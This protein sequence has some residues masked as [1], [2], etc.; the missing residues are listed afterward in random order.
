M[1]T[2]GSEEMERGRSKTVSCDTIRRKI[3]EFLATKEMNKTTFL[4]EIGVN[5]TSL[6]NFMKLKGAYSGLQNG[7]YRGAMEFF[8]KRKQEAK[9][10]KKKAVKKRKAA[11][12]DEEE[13]EEVEE[14]ENEKE[15]ADDESGE[16]EEKKKA[17]T[18]KKAKRAS[19]A[20]NTAAE[21]LQKLAAHP[22]SEDDPVFD[23]CDEVRAKILAFMQSKPMTQKVF[24]EQ[25]GITP[26]SLNK[27]LAENGPTNGAGLKAYPAGYRFFESLRLANGEAKSKQRLKHEA[28]MPNGFSLRAPSN[29]EWVETH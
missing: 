3:N 25:L 16:K 18:P 13:E 24:C 22:V 26:A 23:D 12:S 6:Q 19:K 7:T 15:D 29:Y 8:E 2:D 14:P 9:A 10:Q 1:W 28:D 27:F 17:P 11:D 4:K 21:I 20:N 5:P